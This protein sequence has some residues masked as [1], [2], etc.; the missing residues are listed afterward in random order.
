MPPPLKTLGRVGWKPLEDSQVP[1]RLWMCRTSRK[2]G[3]ALIRLRK[4]VAYCGRVRSG[5]D[6]QSVFRVAFLSMAWNH[7]VLAIIAWIATIGE[8]KHESLSS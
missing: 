4:T 5:A 8:A 1:C 7:L 2:R 6:L 3:L